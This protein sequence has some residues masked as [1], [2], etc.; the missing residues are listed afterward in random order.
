MK[1]ELQIAMADLD[2]ERTLMLVEERVKAGYSSVEIIESCRR[3]VEVVGEKYSDSHYYL[4][5]LIMSEEILK[6]VMRI[7]EPYIPTNGSVKGLS[8]VMGTIEGDIHDLGKNIIIY[9]LRSSGYQVHDL[10][11]DV[12]PERFIQAVNETKASILGIS[13]LLS[14]CIGSIKKV[15]DLLEDAGLRDKVKVVVGGYPVNQEVKEFTGADFYANDVTEA[16]RIYR[17]I[18]EIKEDSV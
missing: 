15:V 8:I 10:G 16:M 13:V 3:G 11:V 17:E 12:T 1:D 18:L 6:G 4:S 7:L 14:F 2:E 9:L 5:D